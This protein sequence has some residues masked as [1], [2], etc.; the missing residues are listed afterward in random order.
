MTQ[1]RLLTVP[2]E[3]R[4]GAA[5]T[6][7][8]NEYVSL[9]E[10]EAG[11]AAVVSTSLLHMAARGLVEFRGA[12]LCRPVLS[13]A[14]AEVPLR[15]GPPVLESDF[16]PRFVADAGSLTL[17]VTYF[18]PPGYKGWVALLELTNRSEQPVAG[19]V[20]LAGSLDQVALTVFSRRAVTGSHRGYWSRWSR[21]AV[22][23]ASA[24]V[25]LAGVA[26]RS[27]RGGQPLLDPHP[28]WDRETGGG[29]V[30][31]PSTYRLEEAVQLTPGETA[32]AAFY[33]G[34]AP[35]GDGAGLMT[36]DLARHG[37]ESLLA[38]TQ[39]YLAARA[40]PAAQLG[41]AL[42][43]LRNRNLFFCLFFAAGRTIDT[44]EL[45]LVTSRSPRYYVCAAHW[46][47]D[48]LL[49]A[50]P[51]ALSADPPL[52]REWLVTAF[53]RYTRN[54][55]VH[56]QYLDGT[57]L[58]PGFE[59]D[60]LCAFYVSLGTYLAATDD[61]NVLSEPAVAGALPR[62]A[63]EIERHRD[64]ATGLARTFLLSS[65]DPAHYPY[66]TYGNALLSHAYGVMADIARRQG[67]PAVAQTAAAEA[68]R[69]RA[70]I[71]RHCVVA[72]PAG[73]MFCGSADL[74]GGY[75]LYDEPPGSLELVA[76]YGLVSPDD[77]VYRNTVDWIYSPANPHGPG[78][79][80]FATPTCP[81]AGHPWTLSV[82]NALLAGQRGW[83][84]KLRLLE[85][86]GGFA[87]ETF[88]IQTGEVRTG[89]GFATCAGF[90]A[91][92]I[93]RATAT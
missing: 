93:D 54:P 44:E 57:V 31:L 1:D 25:P 86:D 17:A 7:T 35:E 70:A 4:P 39:A 90:L 49:W 12:P 29:H 92:A 58:Y 77:P 46:S 24:G 43:G 41:A 78:S 65:D 76:H 79:G 56:A 37:W 13:V 28:P 14:G 59:L 50:F 66:V 36:V 18:A 8:G 30:V 33:W 6:V 84:P 9:P 5:Y 21:A 91:Y 87:C 52:A 80:P 71:L 2:D 63:A 74:L 67:Q 42:A 81:H 3:L 75:V 72:G 88:D 73:P 45:V 62:L 10:I 38:E 23:E 22:W 51:A 85:L 60:E 19:G 69:V 32:R 47:R 15:F 82:A 89:A 55:G 48:S 27:E 26:L 20:G 61:S 40:R 53:G 11:T 16:I 68:E 83:L 64:P 34:A